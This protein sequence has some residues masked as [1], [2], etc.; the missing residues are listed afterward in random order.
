MEIEGLKRYSFMD[1]PLARIN[2]YLTGRRVILK[3][4]FIKINNY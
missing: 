3:T 1:I 2:H 4:L